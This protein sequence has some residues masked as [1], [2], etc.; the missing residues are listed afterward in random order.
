[1]IVY[2][3]MFLVPMV[4]GLLPTTADR[5]LS[6]VQWVMYSITLIILVGLR[7]EVGGDWR[8]YISNYEHFNV[9]DFSDLFLTPHK[10]DY[11]FEII[12]WVSV[13][14]SLGLYGTN[15]ICAIIFFAGLI[16]L[17]RYMP[18]PWISLVVSMPYLVIVVSTG[19]T[20]QSVAI[21]VFMW[22]LVDLMQNK[23]FRFYLMIFL[24]A[25]F[26]K[27]LL[28]MS[29][30]GYFYNSKKVKFY[31]TAILTAIL[32]SIPILFL[33][34]FPLYTSVLENLVYYYIENPYFQSKGA[35]IRIAMSVIPGVIFL[36]YRRKWDL[37][38]G[39][40]RLWFVITLLVLFLFLFS[41]FASTFADRLALYLIP[42]QMVVYSRVL[43][44]INS[45]KVRAILILMVFVAYFFS[46]F[47]WSNFGTH[48][49]SWF[50]YQNI[51]YSAF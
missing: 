27:T 6:K 33:L 39:D 30:I 41:F 4:I 2:W 24:G 46:L 44:F 21:G 22:G 36:F 34:Y 14:L 37:V 7:D 49:I 13:N 40:A 38:Y 5:T 43:V 48:S 9:I 12:H 20:R 1:M 11:G 23:N 15:F 19:Y 51:I 47:I 29:I 8:N 28:I 31:K 17:C 32:L 45:A 50:P 3:M 42:L 25:L 18:N 35:H 26:H 16:R 10:S